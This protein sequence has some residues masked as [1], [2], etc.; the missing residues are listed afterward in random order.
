MLL[1]LV[2]K[3]SK[4]T[5]KLAWGFVELRCSIV[6]KKWSSYLWVHGK[7]LETSVGRRHASQASVPRLSCLKQTRTCSYPETGVVGW[8]FVKKQVKYL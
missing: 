3:V 1:Q 6:F 8:W 2:I 4:I 5:Q 7:G